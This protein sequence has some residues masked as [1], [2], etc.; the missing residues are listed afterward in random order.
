MMLGRDVRTEHTSAVV[1]TSSL[2]VIKQLKKIPVTVN[3]CPG[4]VGNRMIFKYFHQVVYLLLRGCTPERI[5]RVMRRFGFLM[6]PCEMA[7]MSG[8]DIWVHA[9][10]EKDS[11][12]HY[13]VKSGRLDKSLE[14]DFMTTRTIKKTS[15]FWM[16]LR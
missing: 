12:V 1:L 4:F 15:C 10:T 6:G 7:D 9:S 14:A 13:L 2:A 5:D 8:L 16:Q 3:V 11:L